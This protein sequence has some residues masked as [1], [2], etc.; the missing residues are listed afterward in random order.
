[1][2]RNI[3]DAKLYMYRGDCYGGWITGQ[4]EEVGTGWYGGPGQWIDWI[5]NGPG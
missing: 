2:G 4:P 1:M 3:Y 5:D